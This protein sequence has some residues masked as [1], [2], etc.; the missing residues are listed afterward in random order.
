MDKVKFPS[1]PSYSKEEIL[2]VQRV[3]KSNKVNYWTGLECK[4]FEKEFA[5]YVNTKYAVSLANG[6]LAL[7]VSLNSLGISSG[8]EVIVTSRTFIAS[9]SSIV[10]CGA[11]P[12][13]A[14]ICPNSQNFRSS[15]VQ[16]L[17]TKNT[18]AIMCVHLAGF[19]CEM[20]KIMQI[21]HKYNLFVIEDCAQ[22]HGAV[23]RG[24][25]VGSIGHIGCWSF[26]QDKIMTTGGE[27]GMIT[28]NDQ[29]IWKKCWSFKDHGKSMEAMKKK[30]GNNGFRWVHESFGSN[31]RMTEIQACIGRY[32]LKKMSAWNKLR[33][34]YQS[35]IWNY[36]KNVKGLRV[37]KFNEPDW[38]HYHP[39]N[40]HAAYKCYVFIE[41][42]M[43]HSSWSRD[44]I[45]NALNKK[46]IPC[47]TGSCSEVYLEKAFEKTCLRPKIRLPVAKKLGETSLTFLIH[48]SLRMIHIKI[49]CKAIKEVMK[50]AQNKYI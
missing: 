35:A 45:I 50:L 21:A 25:P 48:P 17:I 27:G 32:Q 37:P 20:E 33:N 34:K 30:S 5:D 43:I 7:D 6:T 41:N 44:K 40:I 4:K 10:N 12:I 11:K 46:G 24:K 18:K 2:N 13:F 31:F 9:V 22:A 8:D 1:W 38:E 42:S 14:D 23:Y 3:L 28:T 15:E 29:D 47:F 36:C 16:K 26:C 19:P 39:K 49:I